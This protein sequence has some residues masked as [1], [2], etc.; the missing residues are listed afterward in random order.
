VQ[1]ASERQCAAGGM[2]AAMQSQRQTG[3]NVT[4]TYWHCSI[5][6]ITIDSKC[7]LCP[8]SCLSC[9]R[10]SQILILLL[11]YSAWGTHST[12][13]KTGNSLQVGQHTACLLPISNSTIKILRQP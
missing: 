1:D 12:D 2:P 7:M 13:Q 11:C 9:V 4:H 5:M 8:A 6:I 3:H 10:H